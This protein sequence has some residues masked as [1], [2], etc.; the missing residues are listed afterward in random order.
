MIHSFFFVVSFESNERKNSKG[1]ES[2]TSDLNISHPNNS[3]QAENKLNKT[4]NIPLS[5]T[6]WPRLRFLS[7]LA[8]P[9]PASS[10]LKF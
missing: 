6:R 10:E 4:K 8:F 5:P 3:A 9:D 7:T 2:E 1:F